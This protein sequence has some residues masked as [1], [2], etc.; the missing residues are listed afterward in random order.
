MQ[1]LLLIKTTL[2]IIKYEGIASPN[3][4]FNGIIKYNKYID[5]YYVLKFIEYY[6]N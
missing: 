6:K 1:N 2:V 5:I 4:L 3:F